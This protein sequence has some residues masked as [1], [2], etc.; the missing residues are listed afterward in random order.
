MYRV[1]VHGLVQR[2]PLIAAMICIVLGLVAIGWTLIGLLGQPIGANATT[3]EPTIEADPWPEEEPR[4]DDLAAPEM[5][6]AELQAPPADLIVYV[7]GA[8]VAPDVYRLPHDARIKDLIL[9]AGGLT[10]DADPV[11]INQAAPLN[12]AD[13]VHVPRLG[14]AA[15]ESTPA[16]LAAQEQP[17][18]GS[19]G[20][21]DGLININ[22]ASV[23]ELDQ[24]P[25]IGLAIAERIVAYRQEH[26]MFTSID[27]LSEVKGIGTAL[28]EK[29]AP[30]VIIEE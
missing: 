23:S 13:H 3:A 9:A 26:G 22:T 6:T 30:L 8:V 29:I 17:T 11:A 25:G 19:N 2:L 20:A 4:F 15:A 1:Q 27:Q 18:N 24:L 7:T 21:N 12:D 10:A 16:P 14:Q 28:I 5:A